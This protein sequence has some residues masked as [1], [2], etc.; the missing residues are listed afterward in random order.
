MFSKLEREIEEIF[1]E[2]IHHPWGYPLSLASWRPAVDIYETEDSYLIEADLPGVEPEQVEIKVE[3][4]LLTICGT[5]Q[6]AR[7]IRH[8]N[9]VYCERESGRFCR[10]IVLSHPVDT[11]EMKIDFERGI[12]LIRIPKRT[13]NEER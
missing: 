4:P 7:E 1:R 12:C 9:G 10:T 3:G 6:E 11:D 2:V 13:L 8:A 5:R